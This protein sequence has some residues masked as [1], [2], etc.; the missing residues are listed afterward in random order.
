MIEPV[1]IAVVSKTAKKVGSTAGMEL[2]RK[3][4]DFYGAWVAGA[5]GDLAAA[6][7]AIADRDFEALASVAEASCLK[8]HAVAMAARPG[9]VYWGPATVACLHRVRE[10]RADGTPVFFTIDAG[11]QLKAVC[12]PGVADEV[13]SDLRQ[14]PGVV[15]ILRCG[16]GDGARV[17]AT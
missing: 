12:A 3:S 14:I 10:L 11:P 15:E 8:M 6:R 9:L 17:V 5:P 1:V 2:T 13:A 4:S 7:S 16:L